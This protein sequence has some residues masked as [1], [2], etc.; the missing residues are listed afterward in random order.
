MAGRVSRSEPCDKQ[1]GKEYG[2]EYGLINGRQGRQGSQ[3]TSK[4]AWEVRWI[5]GARAR[6]SRLV[7][8]VDKPREA[9]QWEAVA[10]PPCECKVYVN[11]SQ[12]PSR[13]CQG[14]CSRRAVCHPSWGRSPRPTHCDSARRRDPSISLV[15]CSRG[16]KASG[17][18]GK[19]ASKEGRFATLE[20]GDSGQPKYHFQRPKNGR[21]ESQ[22]RLWHVASANQRLRQCD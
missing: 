3:Q 7:S 22:Q 18:R 10:Q 19:R 14:C 6:R 2:K 15:S 17:K 13:F 20:K 5:R 11:V 12:A 1:Y 4:E 16:E 8:L 9:N 21:A